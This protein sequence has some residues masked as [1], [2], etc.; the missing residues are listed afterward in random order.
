MTQL[1]YDADFFQNIEDGAM[2]SA[3]I[4]LPFVQRH[5]SARS[6]VDIGCGNGVWLNVWKRLGAE[7][8]HGLDGA[9]VDLRT[10][11]IDAAEFTPADLS[12]PID[13]HQTFDLVQSLEVAEHIPSA[14][15][16]IF[17]D[18]LVRHG[19]QILF[20]AAVPGQLGVQHV[21]E[22]PYG[23]W[24]DLFAKR[25]YVLLDAIR[26]AMRGFPDVKWWY[27][28]N[29]FLYVERSQLDRLTPEIVDSLIGESDRVPDIAPWWCQAGRCLT[30][31][32]SV[33][34]STRLANW[35]LSKE[36]KRKPSQS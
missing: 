9:W 7:R 4:V 23:Y 25:N 11:R 35:F 14:S 29:I 33:R 5:L 3:E 31:L 16:E 6:V 13:L 19:R 27:R 2:A 20:S 32:L 1:K 34:D 17:I 30:R 36:A 8:V 24:R 28:Y 22:R 26:P 18:N 15:A 12:Q 21:N 10:L